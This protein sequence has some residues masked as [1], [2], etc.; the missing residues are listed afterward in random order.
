M[1]ESE[2]LTLKDQAEDIQSKYTEAQLLFNRIQHIHDTIEL[3][4]NG[5]ISMLTINNL[6]LS[7]DDNTK[8]YL[9]NRLTD[10]LLAQ[11]RTFSELM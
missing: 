6:E 9:I 7:I 2:L 4:E 5:E 8:F 11:K 1:T 3:I 10:E